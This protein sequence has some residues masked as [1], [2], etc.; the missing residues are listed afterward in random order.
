VKALR[1]ARPEAG[2][3]LRLGHATLVP[4]NMVAL[5]FWLIAATTQP[6]TITVERDL[7]N[8]ELCHGDLYDFLWRWY[9]EMIAAKICALSGHFRLRQV[10]ISQRECW[11]LI[12]DHSRK[13]FIYCDPPYLYA[14]AALYMRRFSLADHKRLA[15]ALRG[16]PHAFA[17]SH[18]Y[19]TTIRDFYAGWAQVDEVDSA[20]MLITRR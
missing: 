12:D 14:S 4:E 5:R 20:D 16:S 10:R 18:R 11:H 1:I 9:P 17:L 2:Q 7:V 13:A 15:E 6:G 3:R 8:D 19:N